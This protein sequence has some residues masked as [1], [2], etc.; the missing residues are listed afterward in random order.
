[1]K[2]K[3]LSA[4]EFNLKL[5]CAL[6]ASGKLG[7]TEE[8][9]RRLKFGNNSA[10]KFAI[11]ED[12]ESILYL[13]NIQGEDEDSFKVNKAGAYFYVNAK[14][15]FDMLGYDYTNKSIMFD[16]I[17]I[18]EEQNEIYKLIKREKERKQKK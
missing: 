16:M 13:F 15:M 4:K 1:M 18:K 5:K 8:T 9:A 12:D 2:F 11:D 10:V 3:I 14:A 17:E 6:H 7:F